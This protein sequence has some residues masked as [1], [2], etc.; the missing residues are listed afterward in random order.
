MFVFN[1]PDSTIDSIDILQENYLSVQSACRLS[2]YNVQYLRR[3]L[4]TGKL[5]GVKIGQVWLIKFISLAQH[6]EISNS[7]ND[8]RWGSRKAKKTDEA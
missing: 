4:R 3:L 6:I 5:D 7:R 1:S 2:G 8:R